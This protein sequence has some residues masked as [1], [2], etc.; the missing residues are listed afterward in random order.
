VVLSHVVPAAQQALVLAVSQQV[1]PAEAQQTV[2][3]PHSLP[4][5]QQSPNSALHTAVGLVQQ[6]P[7]QLT[8]LAQHSPSAVQLVPA[9][10][11]ALVFAVSQQVSPALGQQTVPPPQS[12]PLSQQS[13]N[14]TLQTAAELAQQ[15][16]AGQLAPLAQHSPS[17]VQLVPA[18]Q[19]ALLFAV[20]QQVSPALGQ[21]TVPL[22]HSLPLSQQSSNSTLQTAAELAQQPLAGQL[23]PLAHVPDVVVVVLDVVVLVVVVTH[24][25]TLQV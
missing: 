13:S 12:F 21:Q 2:P 17:A 18:A 23:T 14:S 10:Q 3:P 11:Q 15:P 6:L 4:L 19:Q 20:S 5:S 7:P 22:P 8:P 25:L 24:T 16:L 9:A 1:S